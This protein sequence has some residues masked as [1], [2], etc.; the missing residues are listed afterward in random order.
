MGVGNLGFIHMFLKFSSLL[1]F[2]PFCDANGRPKSLLFNQILA[3]IICLITLASKL[4]FDSIKYP[5]LV[6]PDLIVKIGCIK[7]GLLT[8]TILNG[9]LSANVVSVRN[10][11][12]LR[13]L[14]NESCKLYCTNT[15][16]LKPFFIIVAYNFYIISLIVYDLYASKN[17]VEGIH[18]FVNIETYLAYM[19]VLYILAYFVFIGCTIE[20]F[21]KKLD[22][23]SSIYPLNLK[24]LQVISSSSQIFC[25]LI[26]NFTKVYGMQVFL[27]MMLSLLDILMTINTILSAELQ[28]Y[29]KLV[30]IFVWWTITLFIPGISAAYLCETIKSNVQDVLDLCSRNIY[31]YEGD[32]QKEFK[33]LANQIVLRSPKMSA[34]GF[35]VIDHSLLFTLSNMLVT[36]LVVLVQLTHS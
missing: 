3:I 5:N 8:C 32:I 27:V 6:E 4:Y 1:G 35:F 12:Q 14:T 7:D 20:N 26:N 28:D 19:F 2:V 21:K 9:F 16:R 15:N 10:Y 13:Y 17:Y 24:E 22:D 33:L 30:E 18:I 29:P 31:R 23:W 25:D 11:L 36:Y 34:A